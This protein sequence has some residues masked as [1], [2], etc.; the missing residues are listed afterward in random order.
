[1]IRKQKYLEL[2][3]Q[4]QT[5]QALQ[6]LQNELTTLKVNESELFALSKLSLC[7]SLDEMIAINGWD[8]SK[9]KS[10]SI[11]LE[12]VTRMILNLYR[13]YISQDVYSF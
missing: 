8:G 4:N 2:L 12:N 3:E 6:V 13:I 7:S 11:L 5:C 9:G 1:M 10:R